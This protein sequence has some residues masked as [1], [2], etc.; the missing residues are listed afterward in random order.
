MVSTDLSQKLGAVLLAAGG[1]S[2]LGQ[3]KQLVQIDG[4][5]L[6]LRGARNLLELQ[7]ARVVVVTGAAAQAVGDQI[8]SVP[9]QTVYNPDWSLGMGR[10]IAAGLA[11]MPSTIEGVLIMLCDQWRVEFSDLESLARLWLSD[12]S[13]IATASWNVSDAFVYGPPAIFPRKYFRQLACL[14]EDKGARSVIQQN[15]QQLQ[16]ILLENA[17]A[18]LDLP[19]D[20]QQLD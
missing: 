16:S 6:V 4:E 8:S 1:S 10:S 17:A 11:H 5:S 15:R 3:A 20:L 14:R 19:A 7:P 13:R 12:I 9:V 18:D 2:R